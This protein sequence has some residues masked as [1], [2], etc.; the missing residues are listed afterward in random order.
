MVVT[1]CPS[2]YDCY[3]F[4]YRVDYIILPLGKSTVSI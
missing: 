1:H 4:P 2:F 3:M